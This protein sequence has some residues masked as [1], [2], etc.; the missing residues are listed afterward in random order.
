LP[1][2]IGDESCICVKTIIVPG[3]ILPKYSVLGPLSSSYEVETS[4]NDENKSFSSNNGSKDSHL[5]KSREYCRLNSKGS[6]I[7]LMVLVG[8]PIMIVQKLLIVIPWILILHLMVK[9]TKQNQPINSL[10]AAI[11]W[12]INVERLIFFFAI[13]IFNNCIAPIVL[14]IYAIFVKWVILGQAKPGNKEEINNSWNRFRFWQMS[15]LLPG[16]K[17]VSNLVGSHYEII[18][19]IYRLLGAK[20][21]F[22][23]FSKLFS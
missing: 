5:Q 21:I 22:F 15:K 7:N 14:L 6:P 9:T 13:K 17:T 2:S 3:S 1:I 4:I 20:V 8:L 12:W 16:L 18:S 19:I 11:H 23:F 10:Y